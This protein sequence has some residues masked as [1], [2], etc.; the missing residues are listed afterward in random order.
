MCF[1]SVTLTNFANLKNHQIFNIQKLKKFLADRPNRRSKNSRILALMVARQHQLPL[2]IQ[3]S[4]GHLRVRFP[5]ILQT[6]SL[7][8]N[9]RTGGT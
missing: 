2:F 7:I 8:M 3:Q 5:F 9:K 4:S 6:R 1:S